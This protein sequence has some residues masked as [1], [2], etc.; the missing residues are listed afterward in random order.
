MRRPSGL[1][2]ASHHRGYLIF[3][4]AA[5]LTCNGLDGNALGLV[6]QSIKSSLNLTDTE[7]GVLTGIAF[8]LFY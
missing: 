6:L 2:G 4:L 5:I 7:L 8:S 1:D 3:I